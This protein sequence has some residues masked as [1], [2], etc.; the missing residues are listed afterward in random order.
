MEYTVNDKDEKGRPTPRGEILIR[1]PSVIPGYYKD[2]EKSK[3][4]IDEEGWLA[5]GDIVKLDGEGRLRI[6]DRK[7]NILKL[8]IGEYVAPEKI[9]G[10]YVR[11]KLISEAYV[12]GDSHRNCLVA[13]FVPDQNYLEAYAR[14]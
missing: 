7:K 12:Y 11:N 13:I 4:T 14:E 9:E 2:L 10:V 6:I 3:E 8:Q 1:S 5:T